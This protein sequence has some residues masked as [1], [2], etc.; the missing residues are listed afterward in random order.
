MKMIIRKRYL[1][2]KDILYVNKASQ[3]NTIINKFTYM[4][5]E[6]IFLRFIGYENEK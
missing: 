3:L 2:L 1:S 5:K 6:M 4:R